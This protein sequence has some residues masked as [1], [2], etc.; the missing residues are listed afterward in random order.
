MTKE[1]VNRQYFDW[2][3]DILCW[4][5]HKSYWFLLDTLNSIEFTYDIPMDGNR[6]E[7]GISLRY[8]FGSEC[9]IEDPVIAAYLDIR[10]CSVLEMM[11][12]LAIR[13]EEHIMHDDEYGD[14]TYLWFWTMIGN[15]GLS[16]MSDDHFNPLI[17]KEI[18]SRMLNREYEPDG[19]GG[20]FKIPGC[21]TDL[22]TIEIWYQG[23]WYLSAIIDEQGEWM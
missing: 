19:T 2:M 9:G 14:R 10:P 6:A 4:N 7:D 20:L 21:P 13:Y 16:S 15:L 12:A 23:C 3:Y 22:R 1:Q 5:K 18:I 17:T 8:A 11:A